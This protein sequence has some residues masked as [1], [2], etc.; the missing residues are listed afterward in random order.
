MKISKS[1][2]TLVA[3]MTFVLLSPGS[4]FAAKGDATVTIEVKNSIQDNAKPVSNVY[5]AMYNV[6]VVDYSWF[7]DLVQSKKINKGQKSVK[8]VV[9]PGQVVDFAVYETKQDVLN[10]KKRQFFTPPQKNFFKTDGKAQLCIV[11][12]VDFGN[13]LE[14]DGKNFCG[15]KNSYVYAGANVTVT[16]EVKESTEDDAKL[17]SNVYVGMFTAKVVDEMW[18]GDLF[19]YKK[20]EKGQKNV[21]FAVNPG[22]VVDFAVFETKQDLLDAAKDYEF[23]TPPQKNFSAEDGIKGQ[24]CMVAGIDFDKKLEAD[25]KQFCGKEIVKV[26]E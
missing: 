3:I 23:T 11:A 25:G 14:A 20:I 12:G 9:K 1:I 16:V 26:L 8:F 13:K 2:L 15:V 17:V 10:H 24:V 18:L 19:Q 6:K 22:Q 5:V 7:G 21:K 4:V